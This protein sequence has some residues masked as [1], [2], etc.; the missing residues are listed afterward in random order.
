MT[1]PTPIPRQGHTLWT[2]VRRW[3]EAADDALH[4]DP[5]HEAAHKLKVLEARINQLEAAGSAARMDEPASTWSKRPS[6]SPS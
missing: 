1:N 5:H 3:I 6:R 4:Y 2:V